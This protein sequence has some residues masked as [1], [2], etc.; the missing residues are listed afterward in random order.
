MDA[1]QRIEQL[2]HAHHQRLF[3]L[4]RRLSST[5]EDAR[6]LVQETFLRASERLQSSRSA[7]SNEE[8]WLVRVLVNLCR[9]RWRRSAVRHRMPAGAG[10]E[11]RA[12]G[13][14]AAVARLTIWS[15]LQL[16]APRRRAIVIMCELEELSTSSVAR[17]LGITAVTVRWHLSRGR[18]E[19]A[20]IIGVSRERFHQDGVEG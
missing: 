1:A 5:H 18:Q 12:S 2:F 10:T 11:H 6:D 14:E 19:L 9:D 4:A 17:T 7:V 3:R 8:A 13:E 16:L 15:A 20:K